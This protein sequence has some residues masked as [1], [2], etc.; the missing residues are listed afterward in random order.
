M[1][2]RAIMNCNNQTQSCH[3]E[4]SEGSLCPSRQALRC[5]QD[6]NTFPILVVKTHYRAHVERRNKWTDQTGRQSPSLRLVQD[7]D[8][9]LKPLHRALSADSSSKPAL[10]LLSGAPR[11]VLQILTTCEYAAAAPPTITSP[12]YRFLALHIA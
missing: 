10:Q 3:P 5:A 7:I 1:R 4:R 12:A 9:W 6:D 8:R 11:C 2:S